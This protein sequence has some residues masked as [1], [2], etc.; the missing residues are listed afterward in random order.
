MYIAYCQVAKDR[1]FSY[2]VDKMQLTV[3]KREFLTSIVNDLA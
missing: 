2:F 3:E 1:K